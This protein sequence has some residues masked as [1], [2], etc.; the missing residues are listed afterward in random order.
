M[1]NGNIIS[2]HDLKELQTIT[3][4]ELLT[5]AKKG[6]LIY[7]QGEYIS[8]N[9]LKELSERAGIGNLKRFVIDRISNAN[10]VCK[11]VYCSFN[12]LFNELEE[13]PA[14]LTF[15]VKI[16]DVK[17]YSELISGIGNIK[18]S[19]NEA[20]EHGIRFNFKGNEITEEQRIYIKNLFE[21]YL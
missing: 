19:V 3:A 6:N 11:R 15:F 21:K 14:D 5:V 9:K 4:S 10:A 17:T 12:N 20:S 8:I 2:S 16:N 13:E 1:R 18:Y 7:I